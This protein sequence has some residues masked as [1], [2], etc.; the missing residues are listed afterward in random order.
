MRDTSE[1][2]VSSTTGKKIVVPSTQPSATNWAIALE[3]DPATGDLMLPL[4]VDLLS[5]MGWSEGTD[6]FWDVQDNGQV[7][8]REKKEGDSDD[9]ISSGSGSS[10]DTLHSTVEKIP[11][12]TNE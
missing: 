6:I 3:Q 8:L 2:N 1:D 9:G 12:T 4:P 10:G 5:Q 11:P 7:I